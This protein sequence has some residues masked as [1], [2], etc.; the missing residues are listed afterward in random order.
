MK[1]TT[2]ALILALTTTQSAFSTTAT[3]VFPGT[4]D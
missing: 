4:G 2:L 1:T 3:D